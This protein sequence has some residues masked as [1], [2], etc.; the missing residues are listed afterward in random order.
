MKSAPALALMSVAVFLTSC[1]NEPA[2]PS[3]TVA[4]KFASGPGP[5]ASGHVERDFTEFGVTVEKY[6]FIAHTLGNNTFQGRFEVRDVFADGSEALKVRGRVTCFTVEPDGRT[7]RVGGIHDGPE[8]PPLEAVWTVRDNGEG[9]NDPRDQVTDLRFGQPPGT[10][11]F[12]C[13][14]GFPPEAFG[15]FGNNER[16]NVQ[17]RP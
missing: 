3:D 10:A 4:L 8:Q 11:E 1:D 7:A 13:A 15:T 2:R 6:S 9:A 16:A 17:V 5:Y 12:H 14:V